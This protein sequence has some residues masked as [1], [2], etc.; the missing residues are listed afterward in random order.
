MIV[1]YR[2]ENLQTNI[3]FVINAKIQSKILVSRI[4]WYIKRIMP[5]D[6]VKCRI[7]VCYKGHKP[8]HVTDKINR[9]N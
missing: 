8:G 3:S 6:Q 9:K 7:K 1:K 4:Q 5:Q 2:K